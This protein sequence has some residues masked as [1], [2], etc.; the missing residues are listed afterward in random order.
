MN[1]IGRFIWENLEKVETEDEIV[2]MVVDKYALELSQAKN[3]VDDFI[4]YLK[5]V[6]I[7]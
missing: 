2:S 4:K 5:N 6:D 7:I 3:D 1:N